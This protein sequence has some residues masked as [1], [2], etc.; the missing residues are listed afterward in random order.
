MSKSKI[1]GAI[2]GCLFLRWI[3][4]K[5]IYVSAHQKKGE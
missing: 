2:L 5:G 3:L 4:C 1:I